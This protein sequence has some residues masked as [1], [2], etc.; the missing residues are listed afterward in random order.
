MSEHHHRSLRDV[1]SDP[2]NGSATPVLSADAAGIDA[3]IVIGLALACVRQGGEGTPCI[4][5]PVMT[6][7]DALADG[8]DPACRM[9]RNWIRGRRTR[10]RLRAASPKRY[11]SSESPIV[12][13]INSGTIAGEVL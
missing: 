13:E 10:S 6:R 2:V 8:G 7:L 5:V 9:V 1:H 12:A 11:R 4:P 3:P